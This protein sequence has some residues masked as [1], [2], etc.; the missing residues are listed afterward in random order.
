MFNIQILLTEVIR[1]I[2]VYDYA[3]NMHFQIIKE[4]IYHILHKI[5]LGFPTA[6]VVLLVVF[7]PCRPNIGFFGILSLTGKVAPEKMSF[8][9]ASGGLNLKL[10]GKLVPLLRHGNLQFKEIG[11]LFW[12][13][14]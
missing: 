1:S 13:L 12:L 9:L 10:S 6:S 7:S 2:L 8:L 11:F 14:K 5:S 4:N 3:Y